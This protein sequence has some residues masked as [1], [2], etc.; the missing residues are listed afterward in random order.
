MTR[1]G[2]RLLL[3]HYVGL[4]GLVLTTIGCDT[5]AAN[6]KQVIGR[7][8]EWT[9]TAIGDLQASG[10]GFGSNVVRFEAARL[11]VPYVVGDLY[12]AGP[13]DNPFARRYEYREWV[14]RNVLRLSYVPPA[15]LPTV[16]LLVR[17]ETLG[18]IKY[19][20]L[21]T[22]E[23]FLLLQLPPAASMTMATRQWGD[24][25]SITVQGVFDRGGS[26]GAESKSF[27]NAARRIEVIVRSSG[28]DMN[29]AR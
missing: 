6:S 12:E 7:N 11:G 17:N 16:E 22:D 26:F 14:S 24:F 3:L 29:E 8:A 23:L 28:V 13:H 9:I 10:T 5:F 2:Q 21:D 20:K 4:L 15:N 27:A 1:L 18:T 19:L 25:T